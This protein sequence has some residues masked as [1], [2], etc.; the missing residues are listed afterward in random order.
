MLGMGLNVKAVITGLTVAFGAAAV[1]A[2]PG[3]ASGAGL[4]GT[5]ADAATVTENELSGV[6]CPA[7]RQ[8]MAVGCTLVATF[9][10]SSTPLAETW[11]GTAWKAVPVPLPAGATTGGLSAVSCPT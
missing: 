3:A 4:S 10:N 6:A 5:R 8:C 2:V 1:I 9:G 11:N 7:P